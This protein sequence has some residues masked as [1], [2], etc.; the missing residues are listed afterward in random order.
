[1]MQG[2]FEE[3]AEATMVTK[4]GRQHKRSVR[5]LESGLA[6]A[7]PLRRRVNELVAG[8]GTDERGGGGMT[9]RGAQL[10]Y[11]DDMDIEEV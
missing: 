2:A 6:A 10:M 4:T 8:V 3:G 11:H 9:T 5:A 1:M 7:D